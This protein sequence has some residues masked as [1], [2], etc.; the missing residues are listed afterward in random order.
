[1]RN[2][3]IFQIIFICSVLKYNNV[4]TNSKKFIYP[5]HG[6]FP[7]SPSTIIF[8]SESDIPA[9]VWANRSYT[10]RPVSIDQTLHK[11]TSIYTIHNCISRAMQDMFHNCQ[12]CLYIDTSPL[13]KGRK[14]WVI[15]I[16][17]KIKRKLSPHWNI[18]PKSFGFHV[19]YVEHA[20]KDRCYQFTFATIQIS[21]T[22]HECCR[23]CLVV[24][25]RPT[26]QKM[27]SS[28]LTISK[29]K[30]IP[31]SHSRSCRQ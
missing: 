6:H 2:E 13:F 17:S 4:S 19:E 26:K 25:L 15:K 23:D 11:L 27:A 7:P 8:S 22:H 21:R 28:N 5:Q 29:C 14:F 18:L 9:L 30:Q 20:C 12:P 10:F 3:I 16:R 24:C 31:L 1:M